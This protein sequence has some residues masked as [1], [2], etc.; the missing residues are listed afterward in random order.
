ME[1]NLPTSGWDM[2]PE[3]LE[4]FAIEKPDEFFELLEKD[5]DTDLMFSQDAY[6]PT[7]LRVYSNERVSAEMQDFLFDTLN[8]WCGDV[9]RLRAKPDIAKI[10]AFFSQYYSH[11]PELRD[12]YEKVKAVYEQKID[13][14]AKGFYDAW[15]R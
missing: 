14:S 3:D 6:I 9:V 4:Y 10:E 5:Q 1:R 7:I 8:T 12:L 15:Y 2:S 13:T 11:F